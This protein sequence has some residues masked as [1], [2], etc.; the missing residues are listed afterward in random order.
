MKYIQLYYYSSSERVGSVYILTDTIIVLYSLDSHYKTTFI[1]S[2]IG[3]NTLK[4]SILTCTWL[5]TSHM[6]TLL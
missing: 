6:D 5:Y 3:T 4:Q 2:S 1:H